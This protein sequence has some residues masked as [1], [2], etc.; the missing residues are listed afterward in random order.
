MVQDGCK[1]LILTIH[2][3]TDVIDGGDFVA[4]SHSVTIPE[5]INAV[6]MHRIIWPQM[7]MDR[8]NR[9]VIREK[10]SSSG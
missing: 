9:C 3:V 1:H 2:E 7:G 6:G 5:G 10:G 8:S 4:H